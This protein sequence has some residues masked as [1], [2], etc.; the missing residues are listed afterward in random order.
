MSEPLETLV[1]EF[2]DVAGRL[3]RRLDRALSNVRGISFSEYRLIAA[4]AAAERGLPRIELA[5]AVGLTASAVTRALKPLEKLGY[6]ITRR[7]ERDARRS[8]AR[9]T[10]AGHELFADA[11]GVLRDAMAE[12]PLAN[13]DADTRAKL[14]GQLAHFRP[15]P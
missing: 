3:E 12:L 2:L 10:P 5:T 11:R 15:A 9:L 7:G 6:V 8:L 13:A 14:R 4:L 1:L